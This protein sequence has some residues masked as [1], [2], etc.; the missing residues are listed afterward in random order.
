MRLSAGGTPESPCGCFDSSIPSDHDFCEQRRQQV[1]RVGH[2][3][4]HAPPA[5]SR[6]C[7]ATW[8]GEELRPSPLHPFPFA[9]SGGAAVNGPR[10]KR[11]LSRRLRPDMPF[12][13]VIVPFDHEERAVLDSRAEAAGL[14]AEDYILMCALEVKGHA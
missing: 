5:F 7:G 13:T 4:R 10:P 1:V 9:A 6:G 2:A 11:S 3:P 14:S 8:Q 12:S